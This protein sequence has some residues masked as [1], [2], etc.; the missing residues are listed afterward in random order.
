MASPPPTI[1][2]ARL[3]ALEPPVRQLKDMVQ[4]AM[5]EPSWKWTIEGRDIG[6][7]KFTYNIYITGPVLQETYT[8]LYSIIIRYRL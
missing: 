5:S 1:L 6:T 2:P 7:G 3:G 8:V 4:M